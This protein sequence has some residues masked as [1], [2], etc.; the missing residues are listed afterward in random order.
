LLTSWFS[1]EIQPSILNAGGPISRHSHFFAVRCWILSWCFFLTLP[2]G[3]FP[4]PYA[5]KDLA[6]DPTGRLWL[7]ESSFFSRNFRK[8]IFS[9]YD[10]LFPPFS[11]ILPIQFF[12]L[13]DQLLV[14]HTSNLP[15]FSALFAGFSPPLLMSTGPFFLIKCWHSRHSPKPPPSPSSYFISIP[16]VADQ[17]LKSVPFPPTFFPDL[18]RR[19][20][21]N[22]ICIPIANGP[23]CVAG[24]DI[25]N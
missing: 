23:T 21:K 19:S 9:S 25:A 2:H 1:R 22:R 5:I 12:F 4:Y 14:G 13:S 16:P 3:F 24:L 7:T 6:G 10:S 15:F 11:V 17:D 20:F 8:W 18:L